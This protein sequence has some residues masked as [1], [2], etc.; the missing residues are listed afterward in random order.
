MQIKGGFCPFC[1]GNESKTPPEILAYRPSRMADRLRRKTVRGGRCAWCP[2]S[3]LRWALKETSSRQ[4]EGM[5]DKMNGVGA[6]EVIIETPD[7]GATLADA[8]RKG[9]EDVFWAF[10]DRILDLKQDKRFKYILIF[11][12]HGEA[13][14]A[15][16]EHAHSS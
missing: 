6:H 5:Y 13:A 14:G 1:Y 3:F 10:R 12:N 9:V 11:K 7:H 16:L 8:A 15:S 4:A 2:T